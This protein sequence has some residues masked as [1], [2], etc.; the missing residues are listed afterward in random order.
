[1]TLP[2]PFASKVNV[3]INSFGINH[4]DIPL[5]IKNFDSKK[6]RGCD[7]FS[8]KWYKFMVNLPLCLICLSYSLKQHWKR[9]NF[10]EI[11]KLANV[12]PVQKRR[13]KLLKNYRPISLL[14]IFS[15]ILERV[16]YNSMFDYF[17]RNKLLTP[18][19]SGFLLGDSCIAQ[20]S[21]I[22]HE[23]RNQFI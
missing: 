20:L 2:K 8:I 11:W 19:Q 7:N 5:I 16:I 14:R 17:V 13:K 10:P 6:A 18:L 12:V 4:N 21:S 1:M 9:K 22:I 3:R 15:K 23:I